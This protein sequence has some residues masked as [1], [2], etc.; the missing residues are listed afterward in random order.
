M[1]GVARSVTDSTSKKSFVVKSTK[2]ATRFEGNDSIEIFKLR[3]AP[4]KY[5]QEY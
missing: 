5:R 4:L 2:L 1:I 3:T